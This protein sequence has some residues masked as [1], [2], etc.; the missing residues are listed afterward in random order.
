MLSRAL[1]T[2]SKRVPLLFLLCHA[3]YNKKDRQTQNSLVVGLFVCALSCIPSV[4]L[5]TFSIFHLFL[6]RSL[7][8]YQLSNSMLVMNA[9]LFLLPSAKSTPNTKS[10]LTLYSPISKSL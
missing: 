1:I 2:K 4:A 10:P 3:L 5:N 8:L 9:H 6:Y 7:T